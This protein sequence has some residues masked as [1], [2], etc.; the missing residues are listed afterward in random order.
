[1]PYKNS[2]IGFVL[3]A[4]VIFAAGFLPLIIGGIKKLVYYH[5][6]PNGYFS[7]KYSFTTRLLI[8]TITIFFSAWLSR[9]VVAYYSSFNGCPHDIGK[10]GFGFK[11]IIN[12]F[13][14]ALQTFSMD[15]DYT[16]YWLNGQAMINYIAPNNDAVRIMYNLFIAALNIFA[17]IVGGA[18]IFEMLTKAFPSIRL[19]FSNFKIWKEKYYFSELNENS[20]ALARSILSEPSRRRSTLIFTDSYADDEEEESTEWLL[21]AKAMGAICLKA[22]LLHIAFNKR[23]IRGTHIFLI[24]KAENNNIGIL[25]RLLDDKNIK[26]YQK[27]RIYVFSTDRKYSSIE[28]E[29]SRIVDIEKEKVKQMN[30]NK[31]SLHK[32]V[33][34]PY[35]VPINIVRNMADT[36]MQEVPL[37][38]PLI[39]SDQKG[40]TVT[41]IGG[42]SIGT[43]MFLAAYRFGQILGVKLNINVVSKE[44]KES[45][46]SDKIG[47]NNK[48]N[49]INPEILK[50]ADPNDEMLIYN[51]DPSH[52]ERSDPYMSYQYYSL[53]VMTDSFIHKLTEEEKLLNTDYFIVTLGNDEDNFTIAERIKCVIGRRHL[54]KAPEKKTVIAFSIYNSDLAGKLNEYPHRH[55]VKD[56]A[57]SDIYMYAFGC[58]DEVYSCN[59]VFFEGISYSAFLTGEN[60]DNISKNSER[61]Q[62]KIYERILM[63]H[64]KQLLKDIYNQMSSLARLMHLKY[65]IFSLKKLVGDEY[66]YSVFTQ[67]S[68]QFEKAEQNKEMINFYKNTIIEIS[69][70][71]DN[72]SNLHKLAWLEH[73]RWNAFMRTCGFTYVSVDDMKQYYNIDS[74]E[75]KLKDH[76]MLPLKLHPCLVEC[77]DKGIFIKLNEKGI[78]EEGYVK[79]FHQAKVNDFNNGNLSEFDKLD[80]LSYYN[81]S[82][83]DETDYCYDFKKW[84]YP[85]EEKLT[86]NLKLI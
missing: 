8:L 73:R 13:L 63:D 68:T 72:H 80:C 66:Q 71:S 50:T 7:R 45:E 64:H 86:D 18:I 46:D 14:H 69:K 30:D 20:L 31:Q 35:I 40:L 61:Q 4:V 5:K 34:M 12:S 22:D 11:E 77:S 52:P 17:P 58:K 85:S 29:V 38:E 28:D 51:C 59:N 78:A 74:F 3:I 65:K 44:P 24:D 19:F 82:L 48:I 75:H 57:D 33:K 53:D 16:E 42:G 84:D 23:N 1:M 55:Y 36:L 41:I 79:G 62:R 6:N 10:L 2:I 49:F 21:E 54:T 67:D 60:Y 9:Y 81:R 37:F 76:K 47:F 56:K 32:E 25:A 83:R 39:G 43:E 70:D 15:E 26:T 27:A